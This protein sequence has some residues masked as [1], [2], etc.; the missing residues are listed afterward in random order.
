MRRGRGVRRGCAFRRTP[1]M[2][3]AG[4]PNKGLEAATPAHP[5]FIPSGSRTPWRAESPQ[6][7]ERDREVHLDD[8]SPNAAIG[9]V[10]KALAAVQP[11]RVDRRQAKSLAGP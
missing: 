7:G 4:V 5:S 3:L 11:R 6:Q 1:P 10:R 8:C 2:A 9:A